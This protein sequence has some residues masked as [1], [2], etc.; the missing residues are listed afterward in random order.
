MGLRQWTYGS[1]F[2]LSYKPLPLA[3][4][5]LTLSPDQV[6]VTYRQLG[7]CD[8]FP[9][10]YNKGTCVT[11][12]QNVLRVSLDKNTSF[13]YALNWNRFQIQKAKQ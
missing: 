4:G 11:N 10:R 9:N 1:G 8:L 7:R 6:L 3:M 12:V 2:R 13:W 5:L